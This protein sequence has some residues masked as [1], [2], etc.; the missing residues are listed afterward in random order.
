MSP[1]LVLWLYQQHQREKAANAL[2]SLRVAYAAA[3]PGSF[4]GGQKLYAA[5]ETQLL[6]AS[7]VSA[8]SA[9]ASEPEAG[10]WPPPKTR[11]PDP[12]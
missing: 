6:Q 4:E 9:E 12:R 8:D 7:S 3:A 5:L 2:L 1:H 10:V 11:K